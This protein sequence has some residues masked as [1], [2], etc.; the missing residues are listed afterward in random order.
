LFDDLAPRYEL[1]DHVFSLGLDRWWRRQTARR[2]APAVTGPL[3]DGATGSGQLALALAERYADREVVGLDFSRGMLAIARRRGERSAAARRVTLVEGDLTR[4]PFGD[5]TFAGATV[6]FGVRNVA[7]RPACLR[8]FARVL[9]S[10][11]RLLVLEFAL[12]TPPVIA[13]LYRLYFGRIMPRVAAWFGAGEAFRYLY[14][15]VAMFPPPEGFQRMM[16]EA[17]LINVLAWPMTLGTTV[18]YQGEAP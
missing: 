11:G 9:K 3:L 13:P 2:L 16:R 4:L 18:L 12:P 5:R 10:G 17:G 1:L 8:E 6:A 7:D 15:S 14:Q